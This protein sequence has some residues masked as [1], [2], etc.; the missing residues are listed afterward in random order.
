MTREQ[1]IRRYREVRPKMLSGEV[2]ATAISD[3]AQAGLLL[4]LF[5]TPFRALDMAKRFPSHKR[6]WTRVYNLLEALIQ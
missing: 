4:E 1:L 6:N 3:E 5:G 2:E